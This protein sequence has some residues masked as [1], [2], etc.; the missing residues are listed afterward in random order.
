M[1]NLSIQFRGGD[2]ILFDMVSVEQENV[3]EYPHQTGEF[4]GILAAPR[5][6]DGDLIIGIHPLDDEDDIQIVPGLIRDVGGSAL[7]K[8]VT[9]ED[10]TALEGECIW[11]H[12]WGDETFFE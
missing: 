11:Y 7:E 5:L 10:G 2:R 12:P 1:E 4:G 8:S 3:T 9:G 6:E